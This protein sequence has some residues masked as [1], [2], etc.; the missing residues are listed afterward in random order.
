M[1]AR[2]DIADALRDPQLLGAA[3]GDLKTWSTWVA[4]LKAAFGD[5]LTRAES[6]AFDAVA[7]RNVPAR[8]VREL[9][10]VVGRRSGKSRMAAAIGCYLATMTD[11][12][13]RLAPGEIGYI[14]I[15]SPS[16]AQSKLV[17]RLLRRLP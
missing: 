16:L 15:V 9:W 4:V 1:K 13:S 3:L 6:R 11:A 7:R 5:K 10:A 2:I 8:R 12:R 14:L 17:F